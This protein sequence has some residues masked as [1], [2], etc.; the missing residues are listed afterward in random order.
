MVSGMSIADEIESIIVP[1]LREHRIGSG[2]G[3]ES[4]IVPSIT[5]ALNAAGFAAGKYRIPGPVV[6]G[7]APENGELRAPLSY[8]I[9]DIGVHRD[10]ELVG[11]VESEHD[12][13]WVVAHGGKT[14]GSS[15]APRYTMSSL[16]SSS[17]GEP[18]A[19]YAPLERMAYVANWRGDAATTRRHL[20]SIGSDEPAIHNPHGLAFFLISEVR[21][22]RVTIIKPRIESLGARFYTA[23]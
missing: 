20:E 10:G 17:S 15:A 21:D 7:R 8:A 3:S 1:V 22:S 14:P 5:A 13:A 16:A 23:D 2:R 19:S 18:F 9:A 12:L 11:I 6:L 4:G